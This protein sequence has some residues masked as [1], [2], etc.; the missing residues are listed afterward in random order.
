M[1]GSAKSSFFKGATTTRLTTKKQ[2]SNYA[3]NA[4]TQQSSEHTDT[5]PALVEDAS[6]ADGKS[7]SAIM[8]EEMRGMHAT[9]QRVATDVTEIKETTK[10]LKDAVDNVQTRLA[11]AEGRISELE[12]ANNQARP[13]LETCEKKVQ[14]LW[15][16]VEDLENR[17][18][19]NNIRIIGLKE[20][21]EQ[22]GKMAKY[23]EKILADALG[24]TG[25]EFEIERAHR[26]PIPVPDPDKPPRPVLVRFLR[27]S[28]RDSV[29]QLSREKRGFEWEGG[30]LS[31]FEDVTRELAERRKS[32]GPAK[33]RLQELQ[34][35]HRMIYPATLVFTWDGQ[36][37]TFINAKD[38][39]RF[40]QQQ[41]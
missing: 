19:R 32:F 5:P 14:V 37:K 6:S 31:I 41:I 4:P 35:K 3:N 12:D 13:K 30:K 16:R 7:E 28:A 34:V 25:S 9:L 21:L 15:S 10:E 1:S 36:K 23:V 2:A 11:E 40:L 20:R 33:K 27:S 22:P 24:F 38:A 26:I 17:G 29:I 18:R 8:F 39:D